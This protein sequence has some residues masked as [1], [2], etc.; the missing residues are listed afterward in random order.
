MGMLRKIE[1]WRED[2]EERRERGSWVADAISRGEMTLEVVKG[3]EEMDYAEVVM[4]LR[5]LGEVWAGKTVQKQMYAAL[6]RRERDLIYRGEATGW[7]AYLRK[8]QLQDAQLRPDRRVQEWGQ[9]QVGTARGR[10]D[11]TRR[12]SAQRKREG[13]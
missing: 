4:A 1:E 2:E 8:R 11:A 12:G 10:A 5:R 9:G 3:V 7:R 13:W 6:K